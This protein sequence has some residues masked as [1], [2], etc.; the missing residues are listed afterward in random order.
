[1]DTTTGTLR[2]HS[3]ARTPRYKEILE[4]C[5]VEIGYEFILRLISLRM[6]GQDDRPLSK[7][8]RKERFDRDSNAIAQQMGYDSYASLPKGAKSFESRCSSL[9]RTHPKMT[10]SD[11]AREEKEYNSLLSDTLRRNLEEEMEEHA[12]Q[13][14]EKGRRRDLVRRMCCY[15][16]PYVFK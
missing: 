8:S 14:A 3:P 11:I 4:P 13:S 9:K 1:M 10:Y 5:E 2:H 7:E 6:E 12:K 16:I 15:S